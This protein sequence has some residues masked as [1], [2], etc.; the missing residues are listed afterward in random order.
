MYRLLI[1]DPKK[2]WSFRSSLLQDMLRWVVG[3]VEDYSEFVLKSLNILEI[4]H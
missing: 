2:A 4:Q 3:P 1:S